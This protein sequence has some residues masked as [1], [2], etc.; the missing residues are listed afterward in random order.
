MLHLTCWHRT[1]TRRVRGEKYSPTDEEDWPR[2]PTVSPQTWKAA[3][4]EMYRSGQELIDELLTFPPGRL[5]ENAPKESFDYSLILHGIV[6]HNLYH[7]GQIALLKKL[8]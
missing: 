5:E 8:F 4:E 6:E 3:Q 2:I 1:V 7:A